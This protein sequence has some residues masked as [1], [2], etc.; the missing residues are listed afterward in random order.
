MDGI[1]IPR[2][3]HDAMLS[4]FQAEYEKEFGEMT[5]VEAQFTRQQLI[6]KYAMDIRFWKKIKESHA[7]IDTSTAPP[8]MRT[9]CAHAITSNAIGNLWR[10]AR[11]R[12]ILDEVKSAVAHAPSV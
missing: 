7:I 9:I 6:E 12:C 3:L 1:T 8:D 2:V 11:L 10:F 5:D 4:D